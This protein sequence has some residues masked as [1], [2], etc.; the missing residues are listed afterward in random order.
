MR[1]FFYI[2]DFHLSCKEIG[3]G[4]IRHIDFLVEKDFVLGFG[5]RI[6]EKGMNEV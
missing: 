2:N 6:I 1:F 4:L 5:R 3:G